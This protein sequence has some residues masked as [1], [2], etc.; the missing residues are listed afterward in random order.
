M[1][2]DELVD[3]IRMPV[4]WSRGCRLPD[5]V[6]LQARDIDTYVI[7]GAECE[8]LLMPIRR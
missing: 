4:P 3:L 8:P 1:T 7:N 2:K 6:K 5:H